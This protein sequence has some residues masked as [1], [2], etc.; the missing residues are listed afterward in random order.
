MTRWLLILFRQR[1][2]I[3][4]EKNYNGAVNFLTGK[5]EENG[6]QATAKTAQFSWA[7]KSSAHSATTIRLTSGSKT[8]FGN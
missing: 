6:V 7:C 5:M 2:A 4:G 8:A 3:P 1:A